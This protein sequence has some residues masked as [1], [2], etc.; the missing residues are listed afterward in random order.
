[1]DDRHRGAFSG[2]DGV[3][4]IVRESDHDVDVVGAKAA[5]RILGVTRHSRVLDV[6]ADLVGVP[7]DPFREGAPLGGHEQRPEP[8]GRFVVAHR[9]DRHDQERTEDQGQ[10]QQR[11]PDD[12]GAL[13]AEERAHLDRAPQSARLHDD[14]PPLPWAVWRRTI[15]TKMSS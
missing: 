14:R 13:L 3:E 12:L 1:M 11:L 10:Q 5:D 4:R 8:V 9:E 15:S 6:G 2:Q 7:L